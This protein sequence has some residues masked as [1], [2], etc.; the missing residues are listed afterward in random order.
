MNWPLVYD[1]IVPLARY[2]LI[3]VSS[4][5]V[6]LALMIPK[7]SSMAV[8]VPLEVRPTFFLLVGAVPIDGSAT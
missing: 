7:C 1:S 3:D 4:E 6:T 8:C 2:S 5:V